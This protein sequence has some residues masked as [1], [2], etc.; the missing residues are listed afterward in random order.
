[1][2]KTILVI[3]FP[4]LVV[5]IVVLF[6]IALVYCFFMGM[7][8]MAGKMFEELGWLPGVILLPVGMVLGGLGAAFFPWIFKVWIIE[9]HYLFWMEMAGSYFEALGLGQR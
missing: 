7:F 1:M 2:F 9:I 3:H 8:L 5:M 4:M 6:M